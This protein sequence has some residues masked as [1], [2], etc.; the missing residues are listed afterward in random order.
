M[1]PQRHRLPSSRFRS[2]VRRG[3]RGFSPLF[4]VSTL[5]VPY[6]GVSLLIDAPSTSPSDPGMGVPGQQKSKGADYTRD[7]D[8][9]FAR[10]GLI[11]SK[12]VGNSV[13]RHNVARK[14]RHQ[15]MALVP[16]LRADA[17]VV[18]RAFPEVAD[19]SSTEIAKELKRALKKSGALKVDTSQAASDAVPQA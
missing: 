6:A 2:V 1:L 8:E 16:E 13:V 14:L 9:S 12:K 7:V 11:V 19:A 4:I 18:V 15:F 17:D 3:A 10:C 5:Q